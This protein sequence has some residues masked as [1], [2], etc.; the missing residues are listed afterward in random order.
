M[1]LKLLD[2]W[3]ISTQQNMKMSWRNYNFFLIWNQT[4]LRKF[5]MI[6]TKSLST[7]HASWSWPTKLLIRLQLSMFSCPESS[8]L[9]SVLVEAIC[10]KLWMSTKMWL[11]SSICWIKSGTAFGESL[12]KSSA[13]W[14]WSKAQQTVTHAKDKVIKMDSSKS[15]MKLDWTH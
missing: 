4:N 5:L 15:S 8:M 13:N 2:T 12:I 14:T 6:S 7:M 1:R 3:M 10:S 11:T 9:Q